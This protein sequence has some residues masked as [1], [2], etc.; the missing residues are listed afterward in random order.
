MKNFCFIDYL[1]F[2]YVPETILSYRKLAKANFP[3]FKE[4]LKSY[5]EEGQPLDVG[6]MENN[7]IEALHDF[8]MDCTDLFSECRLARE[9]FQE[10]FALRVRNGGVFGYTKAWDIVVAESVIGICATGAT[11]G[12]CYISFTGK[13]C[14]LLNMFK[15]QNKLRVLPEVKITRVDIALDDHKGLTSYDDAYY[16]YTQKEFVTRGT[17]PKC[18]LHAS[19][20]EYNDKTGQIEFKGGR[21]FE[22][23]KRDSGK[24]YRGYE[25]GRQQGQS[26]SQWFRHEVELRSAQREIPLF[27]LTEPDRYFVGFYPYLETVYELITNDIKQAAIVPCKKTKRY[28]QAAHIVMQSCIDN[29]KHSA[30][31]LVNVMR[32]VGMNNDEI[33]DRLIRL[34]AIPSKL[35]LAAVPF[36]SEVLPC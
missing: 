31:A 10:S 4:F 23:G 29:A 26:D 3:T 9:E 33:V 18:N 15:L 7:M 2:S 16:A 22:V 27:V 17:P 35:R 5:R 32:Q 21:T 11:S 8:F 12:T 14:A 1:S 25:K 28:K 13:G 6:L 30:G 34:N 20:G 36:K 24:L 19:G